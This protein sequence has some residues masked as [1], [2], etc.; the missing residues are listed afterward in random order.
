MRRPEP[1]LRTVRITATVSATL[2]PARGLARDSRAMTSEFAGAA[3]RRP[4]FAPQER[5]QAEALISC[6]D[7][8]PRHHL[9]GD[10]PDPNDCHGSYRP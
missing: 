9:A 3:A 6:T 8:Q 10:I 4:G 2:G 5:A 1:A 7:L